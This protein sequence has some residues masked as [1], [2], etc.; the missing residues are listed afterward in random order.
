[1]MMTHCIRGFIRVQEKK[2]LP[3]LSVF[4]VHIKNKDE[5]R[6]SKTVMHIKTA[7]RSCFRGP[8]V[9]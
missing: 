1:M 8:G 9:V 2:T 7:L 6:A 4:I 5:V 3:L